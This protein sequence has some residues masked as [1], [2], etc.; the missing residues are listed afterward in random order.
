MLQ[1][2]PAQDH[3]QNESD[4]GGGITRVCITGKQI[5]EW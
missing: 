1:D 4:G 3:D 2:W 5:T